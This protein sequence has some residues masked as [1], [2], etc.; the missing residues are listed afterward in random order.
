MLE[1]KTIRTDTLATRAFAFKEDA[2]SR[3]RENRPLETRHRFAFATEKTNNYR[4]S[5]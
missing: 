4:S 3:P 1:E 2:L 5:D